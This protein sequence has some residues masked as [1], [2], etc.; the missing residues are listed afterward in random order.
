[1]RVERL[2]QH[3]RWGWRACW[4]VDLPTGDDAWN[5]EQG[6]IRWWRGVL[7]APAAYTTKDMPQ[8]G[9]TETVPCSAVG[10]D[11]I[12]AFVASILGQAATEPE[13]V[14]DRPRRGANG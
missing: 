11:D 14:A 6:V 10:E 9:A 3:R 2:R 4:T 8:L 12:R 7:R 1:V 5:A 13:P